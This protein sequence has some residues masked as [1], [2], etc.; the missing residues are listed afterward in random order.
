MA[1]NMSS[2]KLWLLK[3]G[4][5][6]YY[7]GTLSLVLYVILLPKLLLFLYEKRI[8]NTDTLLIVLLL[9]V[10]VMVIIIHVS[11]DAANVSEV[12]KKLPAT[13]VIEDFGLI[14]KNVTIRDEE[15]RIYSI[16]F[17]KLRG[18]PDI[19]GRREDREYYTVWTPL[20]RSPHLPEGDL[21]NRTKL[22]FFDET[23]RE[24]VP[25]LREK[26]RPFHYSRL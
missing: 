20:R 26:V 5:I 2:K 18:K 19:Y 17:H 23:L 13:F 11:S 24:W 9:F 22:M 8:Y 4:R 12:V 21:F 14:R 10:F 7:G 1:K 3:N 15:T 16:K 25:R 6:L